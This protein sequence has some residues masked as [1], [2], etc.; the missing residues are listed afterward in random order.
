[1]LLLLIGAVLFVIF[2]LAWIFQKVER[3]LGQDAAQAT[4]SFGCLL[5]LC[6]MFLGAIV[7]QYVDK[8]IRDQDDEQVRPPGMW[9]KK[10]VAFFKPA[11]HEKIFREDPPQSEDHTIIPPGDIPQIPERP[12]RRGRKPSFPLERWLPVAIKW[13][14]RDPIWDAFTLGELISEHIGTNSDG[15]P[16][17]SEQAYYSTWRN[18]ALD[19]LKRRAEE[20]KRTEKMN[21]TGGRSDSSP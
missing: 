18:R 11:R 20:K 10:S 19:E 12:P 13:E 9:L 3:G 1:M 5:S 7:G 14:S 21:K 2:P 16:I 15:S 6:I 8:A 17:I 4:L